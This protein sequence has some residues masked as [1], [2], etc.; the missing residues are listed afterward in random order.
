M[1]RTTYNAVFAEGWKEPS[2]KKQNKIKQTHNIEKY[3]LN[4]YLWTGCLYLLQLHP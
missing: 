3:L 1:V 4:M 2:V